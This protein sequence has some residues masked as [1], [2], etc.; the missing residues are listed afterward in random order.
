MIMGCDNQ[1]TYA[2]MAAMADYWFSRGGNTFDTAHIYGKGLQEKLFGQWVNSRGI[3]RDAVIIGKGGHTP[4]CFPEAVTKQL[5]ESLDRMKLDSVDIYIMHRDNPEVPAGEFIDMLNEHLAAGRFKVFGGSNWTIGRIEEANLYASRGKKQGFSL[6]N[7]NFSLARMV[8]PVWRG[9]ISVSD[10]V[11]RGWLTDRQFPNFSWSS[12][13]RG[14]FTEKSS[15]GAAPDPGLQRCWYSEENFRRRERARDLA[16]KKGVLA[17][18]IAAAF[19]LCQPFPS[20]ALIGPRVLSEA[21]KSLPA[22][23]I[24]LT[25]RELDYLELKDG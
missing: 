2:H 1:K 25:G 21:E 3:R 8:Q 18:N 24:R 4:Y 17:V 22:L 16:E 14:F 19:V 5:F 13:A 7:N 12:Q 10:P 11:S 23:D 9:C 20:Y 15:P 6:L